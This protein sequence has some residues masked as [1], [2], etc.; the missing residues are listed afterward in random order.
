MMAIATTL[1]SASGAE[2]VLRSRFHVDWKQIVLLI[3]SDEY[4]YRE[5][6][7]P[8]ICFKSLSGKNGGNSERT[9][10]RLWN[11]DTAM[12]W[13]AFP[14]HDGAISAGN[15]HLNQVL[16]AECATMKKSRPSNVHSSLRVFHNLSSLT[17][18][19]GLADFRVFSRLSNYN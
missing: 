13:K 3:L 14:E 6:G 7:V 8:G 18:R 12:Y 10:L 17:R 5:L 2:S 19:P 11:G 9:T 16:E 15:N 4:G 1:V